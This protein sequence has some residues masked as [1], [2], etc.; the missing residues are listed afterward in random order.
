MLITC[1]VRNN[2]ADFN[3]VEMRLVLDIRCSTT[4]TSIAIQ[5][6]KRKSIHSTFRNH[7]D[8]G[9]FDPTKYF[10]EFKMIIPE[11]EHHCYFKWNILYFGKMFNADVMNE[12]KV[13]TS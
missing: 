12:R 6:G 13:L 2:T 11:I 1:E 3:A 10:Q 4:K 8:I 9:I 5:K 7:N